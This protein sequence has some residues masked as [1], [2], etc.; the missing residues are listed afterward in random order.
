MS[1]GLKSHH[2]VHNPKGGWDVKK[3]GADRAS[4]HFDLKSKATIEGRKMSINQGTE[5]FIHG[6][7]GKIQERD[8]HGHDPI[9]PRG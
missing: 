6:K 3:N 7:D 8:S 2:V 4:A 1:K 5:F 9:P